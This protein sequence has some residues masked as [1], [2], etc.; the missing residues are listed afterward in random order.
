MK[1][2]FSPV[3]KA[4][5]GGGGGGVE[6]PPLWVQVKQEKA[7]NLV[8]LSMLS[9]GAFKAKHGSDLAALKGLNP[10]KGFVN[11]AAGAVCTSKGSIYFVVPWPAS[12]RSNV[13]EKL[14]DISGS[15]GTANLVVSLEEGCYQEVRK[16]AFLPTT[17][18]A[19]TEV[20]RRKKAKRA[21]KAQARA[22]TKASKA[23]E[24]AAAA[25][26]GGSSSADLAG[27]VSDEEVEVELP[28]ED[29]DPLI[30]QRT[31]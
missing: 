3:P 13:W 14:G 29:C 6:P 10:V 17:A 11:K 25:S 18:E 1:G 22:A 30:F 28:L 2:F 21:A 27:E 31:S 16:K 4:S 8:A 23:A 5:G 20:A 12:K 24:A 26:G 9:A 7:E 19:V 15:A